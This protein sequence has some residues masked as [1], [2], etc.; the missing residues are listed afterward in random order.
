M[1][2]LDNQKY[3]ALNVEIKEG[4]VWQCQTTSYVFENTQIYKDAKN[5]HFNEQNKPF[6]KQKRTNNGNY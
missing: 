3:D 6:N 5:L 2:C 4:N 1:E